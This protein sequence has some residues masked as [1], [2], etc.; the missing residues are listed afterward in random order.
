MKKVVGLLLKVLVKMDLPIIRKLGRRN[1]GAVCI[2]LAGTIAALGQ[3]DMLTAFPWLAAHATTLAM[4]GGWFM[5]LGTAY[6]DD[7]KIET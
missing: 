6:K 2:F 7:P 4:V 3:Q 1:I 5:L